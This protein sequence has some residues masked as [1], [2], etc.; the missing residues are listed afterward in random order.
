[1]GNME[2][3]LGFGGLGDCFIVILKL[4]EYSDNIIYTH[5]DVSKSRLQ[6]SSRLL[7]RFG[8]RHRCLKVNN[9]RNW[10]GIK[11]REFDKCFNVFS[12]GYIDIP[13]RPY[14][15]QPCIDE[16]FHNAYAASVNKEDLVAVQVNSAG[17]RSYKTRPIITTALS[18]FDPDKIIWFGT[19]T[20]FSCKQGTNYVGKTDFI[21]A[22]DLVAR[23]KYFMGFPSVM[24]YWALYNKSQCSVFVDHQG[25][26]DLRIHDNW[27]KHLEYKD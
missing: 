23:C 12:K 16:G 6:M 7:E 24:L 18:D 9:I 14:H 27:R 19:D 13:I 11:H 5:I 1:M 25:K 20:D 21:G 15:W 10:W 26:S 4:L 3:C 22:L 17:P 2:K 8:I